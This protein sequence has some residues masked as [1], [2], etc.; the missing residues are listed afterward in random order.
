MMAGIPTTITSV[1]MIMRTIIMVTLTTI[2]RTI[3]IIMAIITM[4]P[5]RRVPA[6]PA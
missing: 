5:A 4:E 3:T 1:K 6:F 2:T